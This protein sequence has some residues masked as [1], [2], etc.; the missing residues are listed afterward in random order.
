MKSLKYRKIQIILT[1]MLTNISIGKI[2]LTGT[3]VLANNA[4]TPGFI[5]KAV[6]KGFTA[7][8]AVHFLEDGIY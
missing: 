6:A 1:F 2:T 7:K 8:I 3:G 5:L 4:R